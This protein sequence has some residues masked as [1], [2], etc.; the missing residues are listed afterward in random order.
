MDLKIIEVI[1]DAG[2]PDTLRSLAESNEAVDV[3]RGPP[4][5]DGRVAV[6]MLV[7]AEH[8]QALL[9]AMQSIPG[10]S[11]TARVLI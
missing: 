6:R 7:P 5:E 10:V 11:E 9:D 2:H 8:R 4:D 3:W 1:A